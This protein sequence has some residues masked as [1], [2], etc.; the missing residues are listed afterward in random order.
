MAEKGD[1]KAAGDTSATSTP[2][3]ESGKNAKGGPEAAATPSAT[4]DTSATAGTASRVKAQEPGIPQPPNLPKGIEVRPAGAKNEDTDASE[5]VKNLE[6]GEAPARGRRNPGEGTVT[7]LTAGP[8]GDR[9]GPFASDF[10]GENA[11]KVMGSDGLPLSG[12]SSRQRLTEEKLNA[13]SNAEIRAVAHDRGYDVGKGTSGKRGLKAAF[14]K[15]QEASGDDLV[16]P[17][18]PGEETAK[19]QAEG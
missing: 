19:I 2:A 3:A 6:V 8:S 11:G 13:M 1:G 7:G 9:A 4:G 10:R 16:D 14:L 18:D 5:P 12:T 15:A 17:V